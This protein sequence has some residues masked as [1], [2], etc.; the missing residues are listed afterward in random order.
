MQRWH[1]QLVPIL[2]DAN[3]PDLRWRVMG[4]CCAL[5]LAL[6]VAACGTP[7]ND[8][9]VTLPPAPPPPG[10]T[11]V[12][13]DDAWVVDARPEAALIVSRDE[14]ALGDGAAI[15]ALESGRLP[16]GETRD[17]L[18]P[19]LHDR[20]QG[21][22]APL[23]LAFDPSTPFATVSRVIHTAAG[24]GR[25]SFPLLVRREGA[26]AALPVELPHLEIV[27]VLA[28]GAVL[29]APPELD[30]PGGDAPS[31]E[32]AVRANLSITIVAEGLIV[33]ASGGR[34]EAG[35]R[36]MGSGR[37]ITVPTTGATPD[38]GALITC[39]RQ[40]HAQFADDDT[41]IVTADPEIP[42]SAVARVIAA[43][44]GRADAPLFPRAVIS[45]GV[46]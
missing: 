5:L 22:N 34:L 1:H 40:V 28:Q 17:F 13:L 41:V 27:D 20:L 6:G 15:V 2:R 42:F 24:A 14:I 39:L 45:A 37:V 9:P 21:S 30:P 33:S 36:T 3:E 10:P 46:R 44:R 8:A 7:E 12:E 35:C 29:D 31:N 43:S 25:S 11:L 4:R 23:V 26:I 38:V 18:I 19:R 32:V 16:A